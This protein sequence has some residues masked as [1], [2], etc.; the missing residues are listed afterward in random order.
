MIQFS[1]DKQR[2][3]TAGNPLDK[4]EPFPPENGQLGPEIMDFP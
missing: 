4:S 1:S 3:E 2:V